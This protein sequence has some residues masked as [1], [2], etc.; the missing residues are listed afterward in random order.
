MAHAGYPATWDRGHQGRVVS[1]AVNFNVPHPEVHAN[2]NFDQTTDGP[3]GARGELS[4]GGQTAAL[5]PAP[6]LQAATWSKSSIRELGRILSS[7]ALSKSADVLLAPTVCCMRNP[8]GGRNFESFSED[9]VLSG[10]LAV[11]YVAGVQESGEVVA[12]AK[13]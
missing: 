2:Q 6:V 9:P 5:L 1:D 11:E 4:V 3:A 7:E 13:H 12:T 8:L 10:K